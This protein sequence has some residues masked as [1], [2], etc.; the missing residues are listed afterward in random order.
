MTH[1]EK[2]VI[3]IWKIYLPFSVTKS[4]HPL[5]MQL[6]YSCKQTRHNYLMSKYVSQLHNYLNLHAKYR[7]SCIPN[8]PRGRISPG[9]PY[10]P[11]MIKLR[12]V[13]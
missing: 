2:N 12:A 4:M 5:N 1:L 11:E 9:L 10:I 13:P 6:L 8:M 3:T 7:P